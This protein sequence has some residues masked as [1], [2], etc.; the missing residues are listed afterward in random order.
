MTVSRTP[1]P[2]TGAAVCIYTWF[3]MSF[4]RIESRESLRLERRS[5]RIA[6][7]ASRLGLSES[8]LPNPV[9]RPLDRRSGYHVDQRPQTPETDRHPVAR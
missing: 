8:L 7:T 2:T 3:D 4:A 9:A 5:S 6:G 1:F